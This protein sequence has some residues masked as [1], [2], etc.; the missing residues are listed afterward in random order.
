MITNIEELNVINLHEI[1][2][3]KQSFIAKVLTISDEEEL[4]YHGYFEYVSYIYLEK[5]KIIIDGTCYKVDCSGNY[6]RS[7][8]GKKLEKL[9]LESGDII[10]FDAI[11]ENKKIEFLYVEG[12]DSLDED[13]LYYEPIA[14]LPQSY[15]GFITADIYET[16]FTQ[17]DRIAKNNYTEY[18]YRNDMKKA[19]KELNYLREATDNNTGYFSKIERM[20]FNGKHIKNLS[21]IEKF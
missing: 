13:K 12:E 3:G 20:Y 9:N 8:V 1:P 16:E 2:S 10:S 21:S 18:F 4:N 7:K 15:K 19:I 6:I 17:F 11:V 5:I 14:I